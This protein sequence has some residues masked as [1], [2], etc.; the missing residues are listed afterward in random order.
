[1]LTA[2]LGVAVIK[3]MQ[4]RLQPD[5]P[6]LVV[7]TAKHFFAYNLESDFVAGGTD[8]QYRL[9]Y[10]AVVSETDLRQTFLPAFSATIR[11][12]NV[13]S[14]MCSCECDGTRDTRSSLI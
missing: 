6:P 13:K 4:K 11:D 8:A 14:I 10:D 3:G 9:K 5:W 1:M 7:A 12:G 2:G